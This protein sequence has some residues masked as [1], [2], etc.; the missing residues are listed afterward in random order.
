LSWP[1][2]DL[3]VVQAEN[4]FVGKVTIGGDARFFGLPK[5]STVIDD[6]PDRV[7][8]DLGPTLLSC[9]DFYG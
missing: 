7:P 4:D 9:L 5:H 8:R 2:R 6:E 3:Q 1:R